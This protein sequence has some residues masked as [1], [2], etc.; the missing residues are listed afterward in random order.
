MKYG[1]AGDSRYEYR[2]RVGQGHQ[3]NVEWPSARPSLQ[4]GFISPASQLSQSEQP[5]FVPDGEDHR[6][7]R[8]GRHFDCATAGGFNLDLGVMCADICR[9]AESPQIHAMRSHPM[10]LSAG[11]RPS[12]ARILAKAQTGARRRCWPRCSG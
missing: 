7:V 11:C 9:K 4:D 2:T 5:R 8:R 1:T 12:N 10:C 3:V 6:A